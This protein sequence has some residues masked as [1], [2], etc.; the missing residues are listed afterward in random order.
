MND[1]GFGTAFDIHLKCLLIHF[2]CIFALYLFD[3]KRLGS[4]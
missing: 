3:F 4:A 1:F 2:L